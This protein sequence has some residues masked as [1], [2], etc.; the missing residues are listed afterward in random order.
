MAVFEYKGLDSSGR[1]L[2]GRLEAENLKSARLDLKKQGIFL[3]EIKSR[4]PQS[5]ASPV[6]FQS[7]K[8]KTKEL[9]VFTRLLASLLRS[10]IPL[11]EALDSISLQLKKGYFSNCIL[12]LKN[13][14]N[15]GK[16]FHL[17][18]KEYPLIFDT[19]Y[20]SLCESGEATGALDKILEEIAVLME[21]RS[22]I[23]NKVLMAMFY[24]GILLTI[25]LSVMIVLCVYVIPNLMELFEEQKEIPWMTQVTL[26][27]SSFLVNYWPVLIGTFFVGG[28]LFIKWK[29]TLGGKKIWD[30]LMLS[31]PVFGR[32]ARASDIALFAKILAALL[33]GGVPVLKSFDIVKNVLGNYWIQRAVK[34][35][36]DNIKEGES[37]ADP[38]RRS[39]QFPP[40]VLQMVSAG[41]KTGELEKML[42]QIG[43]SYD[44][45]V[46]VEAGALTALLGPLMILIMALIVAFIL[47]SVLLPMLSSF[48]TLD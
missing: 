2:K 31:L 10:G 19:I 30:R 32:L 41:E 46:E 39:G 27:L 24:P 45:Q 47:M 38:L 42:D 33:R 4:K 23:Q 21:K 18:L 44:R 22:I 12:N 28:A 48:D 14:V 3:Q 5:G 8:V 29:R 6:V 37:I 40:V 11:V 20:V 36:R 43:I 25:A 7:K 16:P 34:D 17:A 26:G 35:A 13:Q 1:F 15:E 9:A